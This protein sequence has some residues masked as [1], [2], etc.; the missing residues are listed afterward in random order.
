MQD[1]RWYKQEE[2]SKTTY[3]KNKSL[4]F[5]FF[6]LSLLLDSEHSLAQTL[7]VDPEAVN[8]VEVDQKISCIYICFL[9]VDKDAE[10]G[11]LWILNLISTFH[12]DFSL[13]LATDMPS[14]Y[15]FIIVMIGK[16]NEFD[17]QI[18]VSFYVTMRKYLEM[19]T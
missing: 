3:D 7:P 15:N 10:A 18:L 17:R 14:G 19:H 8:L 2:L 6:I 13:G 16:K 5:F 4:P 12:K 1:H 11:I 9:P